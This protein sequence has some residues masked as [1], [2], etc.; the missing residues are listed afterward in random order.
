MIDPPQFRTCKRHGAQPFDGVHFARHKRKGDNE[1]WDCRECK[2][3]AARRFARQVAADPIRSRHYQEKKRAWTE[4]NRGRYRVRHRQVV[5]DYYARKTATPEGLTEFT[6]AKRMHRRA[7]QPSN[8]RPNRP[9][10][11]AYKGPSC[12]EVVD[13]AP[14]LAFIDDRFPGLT[15]SEVAREIGYAVSERRLRAVFYEGQ[16]T[17]ELD[18]VDRFLTQGLGRPD[19]LNAIYPVNP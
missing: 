16:M 8:M 1:S 13:V 6:V 10:K 2:R 14:L 9:T 18:T 19:L 5:R 11:E 17:M 4:R 7:K 12:A 3:E 15:P